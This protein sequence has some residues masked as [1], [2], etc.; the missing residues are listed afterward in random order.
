MGNS[1]SALKADK[2][3]RQASYDSDLDEADDT[4]KRSK[5]SSNKV[6]AVFEGN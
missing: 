6:Q 3:S 1:W 4:N 2:I 5:C